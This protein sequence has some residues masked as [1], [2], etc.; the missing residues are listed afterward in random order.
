MKRI[1]SGSLGCYNK[2]PQTGWLQQQT[3]I[4]HTSGSQKT[5]DE[6]VNRT[7]VLWQP[8]S[9]IADGCLLAVS[10]RGREQSDWKKGIKLSPLSSYKNQSCHEGSTHLITSQRHY[11]LIP[12]H[13]GFQ[14]MNW[15]GHKHTAHKNLVQSV[16]WLSHVQLFATPWT[17]TCQASLSITNSWSLIKLMS[18]ESVMPSSHLILCRPFLLLPSIFPSIRVFSNESVFCI[19]WPK[20]W[21]FRFSISPS[22]EYSGLISFRID[23]L[24]LLAIQGTLKSLLQH[25]SSKASILWHLA[26]FIVQLSHPFMITGKTAAFD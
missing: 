1:F 5:Q 10:S 13:W 20:Y 16:Q 25:H 11:H 23:W 15:G 24:Y 21:R 9:W 12:S 7:S 2:L 8:A 22:N 6:G 17:A 26:F 4:S 14:C 3:F 18:I 19:R